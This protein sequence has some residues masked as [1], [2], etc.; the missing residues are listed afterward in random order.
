M[1]QGGKAVR[2]AGIL[3]ILCFVTGIL[4][5]ASAVDDP[6]YLVE[7]ASNAPGVMTAAFFHFLMAPLYAG[8]AI[9]LYPILREHDRWL[10]LGFA[11]FRIMAGV[12]VIIGVI[13]LMMLLSLSQEF[14]RAGAPAASHYQTLG[15]LLQAA[16]DLVNHLATVVSVSM[17]GLMLYCLLYR[18]RLVPRWLSAWGLAGSALAIAASMLF[19]FRLVD[20]IT[21]AYLALNLP[22]ALQEMVFAVWLIGKGFDS[23]IATAAL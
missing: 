10:A 11:G 8:I 4:S 9:A 5:I 14:V 3:Y 18:T 17:G 20:I 12:F 23:S 7:A 22:V 15:A 2:I 1:N 21:P 16:R 13:V 19:L 6:K